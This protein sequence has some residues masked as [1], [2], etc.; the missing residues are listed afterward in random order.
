[1]GIDC[2]QRQT[3]KTEMMHRCSKHMIKRGNSFGKVSAI[4][5]SKLCLYVEACEQYA[6]DFLN[7][8]MSNGY[9]DFTVDFSGEIKIPKMIKYSY[10]NTIIKSSLSGRTKSQIIKQIQPLLI[11]WI[12]EWNYWFRR[13]KTDKNVDLEKWKKLPEIKNFEL[14]TA[15]CDVEINGGKA[16]LE[17][18][19]LGNF[20]IKRGT[21]STLRIPFK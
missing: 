18:K 15:F 21:A 4:K 11:N 8:V 9:E 20:G 12:K 17:L 16:F 6:N 3:I 1:M 13:S 5:Y 10:F 14:T 2:R 7:E 19:A